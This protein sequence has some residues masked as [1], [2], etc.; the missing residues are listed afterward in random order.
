VSFRPRNIRIFTLGGLAAL[1]LSGVAACSSNNAAIT[2]ASNSNAT[3]VIG[4][5]LR[6][7]VLDAP[8]YLDPHEASSYPESIVADNI[9]DKL[10]WQDPTTGKLYPWLATSWSYNAQLTEFTFHL[11]KG[12]TFSNGTPFNSA[13]VKAN[14]DQDAFGDAKL[15]ITADPTHWTGYVSTETPDPYT[16]IVKFSQPNAGFLTFTSFSGDNDPGFVALSTLALSKTQRAEN[17]ANIIGTGPF[18]LKSFKYEQNVVLVRRKGYDWAPEPLQHSGNGGAAYLNEIDIETIPEASVRTGALEAGDLDATLDVQPTDEA[19]LKA[20]GFQ[21]LAQTVPGQNISF[22]LNTSLFPTNDID[23]RKAIQTGWDRNALTKGILTTSYNVATSIIAKKVPGYVD[24]ASTALKYDPSEAEALLNAD[25]WEVGAN[26]IRYKNGKELTVKFL[27][28][29]NLVANEPAYELIQEQLKEIG[30]NVE[31]SVLPIPDFTVQETKAQTSW[32]GV[33]A[34][35]SRDDPSVLWQA[36][37]PVV[38]NPSFLTVSSPAY[39]SLDKATQ[40]I[41]DTLDPT[42]RAAATETAQNLIFQYALEIP[43]YE[44]AQVIAANKDVHGIIFDAQ[45]RNLF[46]NTWIG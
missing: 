9:T 37:S 14:F 42:Q 46:Y 17:V 4:G 34:N 8:Q 31:L 16:A 2:S 19:P 28:I 23:V 44:P 13:V 7:G 15:G 1:A 29:N 22:A 41:Q 20:E 26:G 12:V 32:N 39:E 43:V 11:R 35:T 3:P 5:T 25:G 33:A 36:D 6:F 10:T 24:Y 21:I 30:I 45:S 27:G 18:V 40:E 38:S